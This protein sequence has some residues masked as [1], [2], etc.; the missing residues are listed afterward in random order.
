MNDLL[1][2]LRETAERVGKCLEREPQIRT[3]VV[4]GSVAYGAVASHSDI[5]LWA[6]CDPGIPEKGCREEALSKL[7]PGWKLDAFRFR[8]FHL[9]VIDLHKDV[10]GK[11]VSVGYQCVDWVEAV[12]SAVTERGVMGIDLCPRRP[13][14]IPALIQRCRVIFDHDGNVEE[15]R[16]RVRKYPAALKQRILARGLPKLEQ[17][18]QTILSVDSMTDG[19]QEDES[20]EHLD[21]TK[22]RIKKMGVSA[23]KSRTIDDAL[24]AA[25]TVLFALNEVYDPKQ[26]NL[27]TTVL[28]ELK[29]VPNQFLDRWTKIRPVGKPESWDEC[30]RVFPELAMDIFRIARA[31]MTCP[32]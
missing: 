6:I 4:F 18:I 31:E 26:R 28:P 13:Y 14:T 24:D 10:D 3:V 7:V 23:L 2:Q 27:E 16:H 22:G 12:V 21:R 29:E 8:D 11:E 15:W 25:A 32:D 1:K 19:L 30:V 17:Q 5:D 20:I 9:R